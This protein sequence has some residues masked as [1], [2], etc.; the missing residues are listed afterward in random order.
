[1]IYFE[2]ISYLFLV[3][4]LLFEQVNV[5]W[6]VN[7]GELITSI[8]SEIIRKSMINFYPS[9]IVFLMISGG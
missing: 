7:M 8:L 4:L 3:F 2:H 6:E 9:T 5:S 1:M